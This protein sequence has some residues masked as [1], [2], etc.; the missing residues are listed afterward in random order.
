MRPDLEAVLVFYGVV[1][2]PNKSGEQASL[3]RARREKP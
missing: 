3:P 2:N 1:Y